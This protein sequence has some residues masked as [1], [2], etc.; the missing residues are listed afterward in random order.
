MGSSRGEA[1]FLEKFCFV[2]K[3]WGIWSEGRRGKIVCFM[4]HLDSKLKVLF[5]LKLSLSTPF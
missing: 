5:G 3:K 4:G 1:H 2:R